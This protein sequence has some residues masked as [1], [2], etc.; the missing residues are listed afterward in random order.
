MFI[1]FLT[2]SYLTP[3]AFFRSHPPVPLPQGSFLMKLPGQVRETWV[4]CRQW[5]AF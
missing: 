5:E 2:S 1:Y 3:F 4:P